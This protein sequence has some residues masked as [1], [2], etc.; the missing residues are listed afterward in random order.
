[1]A[2]QVSVHLDVYCLVPACLASLGLVSLCYFWVTLGY[3][4]IILGVARESVTLTRVLA[5]SKVGYTLQS[6]PL[7]GTVSPF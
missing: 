2:S 6:F 5:A 7:S 3:I 4:G 1:M